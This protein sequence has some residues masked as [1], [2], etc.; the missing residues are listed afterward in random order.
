MNSVV[1]KRIFFRFDRV[2]G[3]LVA[4]LVCKLLPQ[5]F[6]LSLSVLD[7]VQCLGVDTREVAFFGLYFLFGEV[8]LVG[9]LLTQGID[10]VS[11]VAVFI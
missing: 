11:Y 4:L 2:F 9:Y 5:S 8:M 6:T 1:E 7:L 10:A 3:D